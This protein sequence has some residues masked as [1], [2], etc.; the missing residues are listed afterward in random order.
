MDS[1]TFIIL[2]QL[3]DNVVA[4]EAASSGDEYI[5]N[6]GGIDLDLAR[7]THPPGLL[8]DPDSRDVAFG[9]DALPAARGKPLDEVVLVQGLALPVYPAKAQGQL[10]RLV[11]FLPILSHTTPRPSVP[12]WFSSS[13]DSHAAASR[14][15]RVGGEGGADDDGAGMVVFAAG[16]A[17]IVAASAFAFAEAAEAAVTALA[18]VC[19]VVLGISVMREDPHKKK[20][21]CV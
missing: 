17:S 10:D 15:S 5:A 11:F 3:A 14:K 21:D 16:D 20:L 1:T 13:H 7:W 2:E 8:E 9:P 12:L 4:Q 18:L 6:N 19:R